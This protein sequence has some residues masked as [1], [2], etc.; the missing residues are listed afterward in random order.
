MVS[1]R[2]QSN[3][4][5]QEFHFYFKKISSYNRKMYELGI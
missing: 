1:E 2:N 4:M 3:F 5:C